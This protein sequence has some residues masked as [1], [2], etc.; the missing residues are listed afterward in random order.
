MR[1][2]AEHPVQTS[3]R[4]VCSVPRCQSRLSVRQLDS[5]PR[6]VPCF[7]NWQAVLGQVAVGEA[8]LKARCTAQKFPTY[9]VQSVSDC[10]SFAGAS[11]R[12]IVYPAVPDTACE[13]AG[14]G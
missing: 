5:A 12:V 8:A 9:P 2:K 1:A 7:C 13:H 4:F 11:L 14:H 3:V 10:Y 6:L